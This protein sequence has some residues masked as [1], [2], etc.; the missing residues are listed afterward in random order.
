MSC[1]GT[2]ESMSLASLAFQ[3][4]SRAQV[5][6][7]RLADTFDLTAPGAVHGSGRK[8]LGAEMHGLWN[9][10][11]LNAPYGSAYD[12]GQ[13][14]STASAVRLTGHGVEQNREA[15]L[16]FMHYDSRGHTQNRIL[17]DQQPLTRNLH[18]RKRNLIL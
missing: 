12:T 13:S 2:D 8:T 10:A 14:L 5:S 4:T 17:P 6:P 3:S 7:I 11:F 9:G 16:L 18:V 1:A 15:I